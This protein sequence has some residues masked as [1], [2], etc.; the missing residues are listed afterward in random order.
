MNPPFTPDWDEVARKARKEPWAR[1]VVRSLEEEM[2]SWRE[3]LVIPPPSQPTAWAHHYFCDETG[4]PLVWKPDS[5]RRHLCAKNGRLYSGE[6]YD[7]AWRL[8][9]H[10]AN[11]AQIE[12]CAILLRL[13]VQTEIAGAEIERIAGTYVDTYL[14]YEVHG[15]APSMGRLMPQSLD[16]AIWIITLLRSLRWSGL[17]SG[18]DERRRAALR[19]TVRAVVDLLRPQIAWIHNIHC[20]LLAA[21]AE[22]ALFL[23][24]DALLDWCWEN[25]FGIGQQIEKGFDG[26]GQW[27]EGSIGYHYYALAALLCFLEA[28]GAEYLRRRADLNERL[29]KA[30]TNPPLLAYADGRLPAYNDCWASPRLEDAADLYEAASALMSDSSWPPI[31]AEV[32]RNH[33]P[34]P[35]RRY[36]RVHFPDQGGEPSLK[37]ARSSVAALVYG[38]AHLPEAA[39][40]EPRSALLPHAGIGI[41]R[42]RDVRLA[43][44]FGPHGGGHDHLDRPGVDVETAGGWQSLDL[45]TTG[46]ASAF[47]GEWLRTPAAHNIVVI[48]GAWQTPGRGRL[49]AWSETA[50]TVE[51]VDAHPG[52]LLRRTL[53]LL[54][55]GW[56]DRFEIVADAPRRID[57]IFH[58]DGIFKCPGREGTPVVLEED[59]G[60][61]KMRDLKKAPFSAPLCGEWRSQGETVAVEFGAASPGEIFWGAADGNPNGRPLGI[62]MLRAVASLQTVI[63]RFRLG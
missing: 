54:E 57:W 11:G 8:I 18:W 61:R 59:N 23:E 28:G 42:N 10:A 13:G 39:P 24:D 14:S 47:N 2:L 1:D 58:G 7:G 33:R 43:M 56:E 55:K 44:R 46:Y 12:R 37:D 41:L 3:K 31:L 19:E 49:V 5:P 17:V 63:A 15:S 27:Y 53:T 36:T 50:L 16:E 32:Y 48:D 62:V 34:A 26:D 30:F 6:P 4:E 60:Y 38:P 40:R 45:G 29:V 52:V 35:C 51:V 22:A 20:W 25:P 9:M 21:L